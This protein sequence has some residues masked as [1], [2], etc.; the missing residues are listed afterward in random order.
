VSVQ[1]LFR[2]GYVALLGRPNVGKST[3]L[4][5]LLGQKLAIVTPKPQTTRHRILGI[6]NL[7]GAQI[8]LVDTPGVHEAR[9]AMNR[10]MVR[11]AL[12][13]S[14]DADVI[15]ALLEGG[16]EAGPEEE[17]LL[18]PLREARASL[19]LA[20]NKI[21][22]IKK[23]ALLPQIAAWSER[24]PGAPVVPISA[25]EGE[26]VDRLLKEIV[27]RLPEGEPFYPP[28]QLTDQP[29][30]FFASEIVREK[31]FQLTGEE[32]PYATAVLVD[33]FKEADE[34]GIVRIRAT[35]YVEKDSQKAIVI[36]KGG[37]KLKEI[38][39]RAR[40]DLEVFLGSKVGLSLW[41]KVDRNWTRDEKEVRRLGHG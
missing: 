21:D 27:E 2:A 19:I 8:V 41:V 29:E 6:K 38:G 12:A 35:I 25:L 30:R 3:L 18:Q 40:R 32:V 1:R 23:A 24:L 10:A 5:R 9:K 4:N 34:R 31:I 17:T 37:T 14:T 26:G 7:P 20:I 13:A 15:V 33:E 11:A 22:R 16:A 36:G 39:S 28:E